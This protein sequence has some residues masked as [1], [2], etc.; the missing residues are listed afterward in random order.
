[1][2]RNAGPERARTR[3]RFAMRSTLRLTTGHDHAAAAVSAFSNE[4]GPVRFIR[5]A[6]RN[7]PWVVIAVTAHV[8]AIAV[9]S[10][11]YV[12]SH[13]AQPPETV[14]TV[15]FRERPSQEPDDE[16]ALPPPT[17]ERHVVPERAEAGEAGPENPVEVVIPGAAP[18]ALGE[19]SS[20]RDPN[21]ESGEFN[22]DPDAQPNLKSGATGGTSFGVHG[23]GHHGS[24]PSPWV[25]A[26]LGGGGPG[27]GGPGGGKNGLP[28]DPNK[29]TNVTVL[30]ALRWLKNHQ[31]PDGRW[32]SDGFDAQCKMNHCDGGGEGTYDTGVTGLALLA[33][34]GA[35]ETHQS[36]SCRDTVRNG[37]KFLRDEQDSE[38]CFGPR[39]SQ[40][41][42]YNHAC[43][44]L[45][46]TEAYG[47]TGSRVFKEPAQRGVGFVLKS[48]NPYLAWRYNF[49]PDGDNDTSV[50]GW[51]VMVLKWL[52]FQY[53]AYFPAM[54]ILGKVPPGEL[55]SGLGWQAAWVILMMASACWLYRRGLRHYSAYGG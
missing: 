12:N 35:G 14:G 38:G 54:V 15:A 32:D 42:L 40:H 5:G 3:G 33:F 27:G 25:S 48:K 26:R 36:G 24:A 44:A 31:S 49:P 11:I 41:F 1:M 20:T 16:F 34:L 29:K 10:V 4:P 6:V 28:G 9:L 13:K 43:A 7:S 52:P 22:P 50:S 51:M 39:T 53:L 37:L 17:F 55:W 19:D 21:R 45:A 2:S 8:A 18:G 47:M 30:N 23:P 46:M